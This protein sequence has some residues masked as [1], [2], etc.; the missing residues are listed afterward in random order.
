MKIIVSKF[1]ESRDKKLTTRQYPFSIS[2]LHKNDKAYTIIRKH[3]INHRIS[4]DDNFYLPYIF[5][6]SFYDDEKNPMNFSTTTIIGNSIDMM[7]YIFKYDHSFFAEM[8]NSFEGKELTQELIQNYINF[9][10]L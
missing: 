4:R 2:N 3:T 9:H 10:I 7:S 1:I 5:Y 8:S 6:V